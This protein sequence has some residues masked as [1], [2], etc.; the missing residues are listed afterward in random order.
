MKT[1]V[2]KE[3]ADKLIKDLDKKRKSK[4]PVTK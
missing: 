4:K 1:K 3:K 2:N